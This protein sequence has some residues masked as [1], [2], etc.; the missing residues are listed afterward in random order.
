MKS[1][2][3]LLDR[4]NIEMDLAAMKPL[5]ETKLA[6]Y[7]EFFYRESVKTEDEFGLDTFRGIF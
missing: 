1:S 7:R 6:E 3:N 5:R 2:E 4:S